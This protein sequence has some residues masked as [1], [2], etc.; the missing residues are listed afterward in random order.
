MLGSLRFR[1]PEF[2]L[3]AHLT[4]ENWKRALDFADRMQLTLALGLT[5]RERLPEWV[6]ARIDRDL[7]KN[8]ERWQRI[9]G[10]YGELARAFEAAGLEFAVLKGFAHC[11]L[12]VDHPSHRWQAD[13]DA[14][15][16][17]EEALKAYDIALGL[18]YEP[19]IR[20]DPHPIDHLPTLVR[21]T[22]WEWRG[23]FFD[24]QIPTSLELH[25]RL[26]DAETE[27]FGAEGVEEFRARRQTQ[28]VDGICFTGLDPVD[29]IGNAAL[30][31]LRHLLR[32]SLRLSHAYEL[33]RMLHHA[34]EDAA[35]WAHWRE[36]HAAPLRRLEAICF[37][38][39]A[40]WFDCRLPDAAQEAI[41]ELPSEAAR[42]LET[43]SDSPVEG[44][45]HPNK[46]ELWLHWSL[47]DSPGARLAVLWRRLVP[48]KLPGPADAV[49]IPAS[50][51]TWRIRWRARR[52][53]MLYATS[54]VLYHLRTLAPT[55][56]SAVRWFLAGTGL[57]AQYWRFFFA[58]GFFDFG[59]FIFVILYN[60]YLLQ[61]GFRENFIGQVASAMTSGALVGSIV[62][63][64]AIQRFGLRRSL[65][66][67]FSL[68]ALISALRAYATLWPAL[69]GLAF[70]AGVTSSAWAVAFSPAIAHLTNQRNRARGF[71]F[72]SS[73]GIA[74]GVL[75]GQAAGRLPGWLTRLNWAHSTID[76]YRE[77]L[78]AGCAM[79]ALAIW[80]FAGVSMDAAPAHEARKLRRPSPLVVRFLI[81]MAV[82]NLGTGALNPFFNVFFSRHVHLPVVQ[83]GTVFSIAQ[84]AQVG[85]ILAAPAVFRRFGL[86]RGI[87]GM[88]L[89]TGLTV[90]GLA[91]AGGAVWTAAGYSAY[92]MAQYMSEPGMFT[93]LMEGVEVPERGSASALNFL[94][95]FAAQ[96]VAAAAAGEALARFGYRPVFLAAAAICV[97]AGLLFRV[98][99]ARPKPDAPSSP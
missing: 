64:L 14:L 74:I 44:K 68:T 86:A 31:M 47:L 30:H 79:V 94:V 60:L 38:L 20:D 98:L 18:G 17:R 29:Q 11:P 51:L 59:M 76:A 85:A 25:F 28:L 27:R 34:A 12:F 50:Q 95:S 56:V 9:K 8:A 83:I 75:G 26:W 92:M 45:F 37:A 53:Y 88:Q 2:E 91:A 97:A 21:K 35:L 67:C 7:G 55:A 54:R 4:K 46:D 96:A 72:A 19:L 90:I 6:R 32:G 43:Y 10:E 15:F 49:N 41:A 3:L 39:A 52:R 80:V 36:V 71:S 33:A 61:L 1:S 70:A 77:A 66:V 57:G 65:L 73:A 93:L 16:E 58:E 63:A 40:R 24:V 13:I 78:L 89:A 48:G 99:L 81:A 84:L 22:G 42:W 87:S 62:A 69:L 5:C 23:D 82:W